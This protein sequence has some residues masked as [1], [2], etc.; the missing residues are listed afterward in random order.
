MCY[1]NIFHRS[2]DST[3][4]FALRADTGARHKLGKKNER[5]KPSPEALSYEALCH[6]LLGGMP[7]AWGGLKE[8]KLKD[9][10]DQ[11]W[12]EIAHIFL[13]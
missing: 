11:A 13:E 7:I 5:E 4:L 1:K 3:S 9:A 10:E 12:D 8:S 6:C 2:Y